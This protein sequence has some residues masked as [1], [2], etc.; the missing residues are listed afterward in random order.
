[1]KKIRKIG[2]MLVVMAALFGAIQVSAASRDTEDVVKEGIHIEDIDVSDMT[3][4]EVKKAVKDV[5]NS[6]INAAVS[7]KINKDTVNTT[8]K[9]LGYSWKNKSVVSEAMRAGKQG[10]VIRRYKDSID[11]KK[12]GK[13]FHVEIDIEEKDF[14]KNLEA[15]CK[16]YNVEA[17]NASLKATGH[18]FQIIPEV[19]GCVVNYSK[20]VKQFISYI[21]NDWDKKSEIAFEATTKIAKPKYTTK[22]CEKVSNEPM[23]TYT[24]YFSAGV[25]NRNLN[26][27]N[28]TQKLS[29]NVIYPGESFSCNECLAPWTED[30]GWHPAGTYSEEV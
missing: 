25:V 1:M 30:N 26:I 11:L 28:G 7:L 2:I 20:T 8:L 3:E 6:R 13:T 24:T 14:K 17:K 5:V 12:Q 23:G 9:D 16:P 18:G 10:N 22:D 27:K 29:D 21:Q 15:L 4:K 19:E